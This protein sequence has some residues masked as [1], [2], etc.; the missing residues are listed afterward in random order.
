M[1]AGVI[2]K[3]PTRRYGKTDASMNTDEWM[4]LVM[5][6]VLA[7]APMLLATME[8]KIREKGE[9]PVPTIFTIK[10]YVL[11][12]FTLFSGF[13]ALVLLWLSGMMNP[14]LGFVFIVFGVVAAAVT[15]Q[16]VRATKKD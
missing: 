9:T 2:A 10:G 8:R 14:S 7:L 15:I 13:I 5:G 6:I 11:T 3:W 16:H 4:I 1:Y 12:P